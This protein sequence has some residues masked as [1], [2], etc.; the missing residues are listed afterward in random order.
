[1]V[2]EVYRWGGGKGR[3]EDEV[4][5]RVEHTWPRSMGLGA[6]KKWADGDGADKGKNKQKVERMKDGGG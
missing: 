6:D 3:I 4:D 5:K 1:M 2:R